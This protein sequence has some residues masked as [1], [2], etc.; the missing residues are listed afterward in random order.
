MCEGLLREKA[1]FRSPNH[2]LLATTWQASH[3]RQEPY[4]HA[5]HCTHNRYRK[6]FLSDRLSDSRS[7][8]LQPL[9]LSRY[10]SH[11]RKHRTGTTNTSW[12]VVHRVLP[13]MTLTYPV[14]VIQHFTYCEA[15]QLYRWLF[16][17]AVSNQITAQRLYNDI[18]SYERFLR[19]ALVT[20]STSFRQ[21]LS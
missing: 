20:V 5:Q 12:Q 13:H 3:W 15:S 10:V 18:A 1:Y 6:W 9:G 7:L 2:A 8:L 11:T 4:L 14:L 19:S 17:W 21:P 16:L